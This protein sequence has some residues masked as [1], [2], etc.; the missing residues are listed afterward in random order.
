MVTS[1]Y[2]AKLLGTV[3]LNDDHIDM[4]MEE[5]SKEVSSDPGLVDKVIIARLLFAQQVLNVKERYTWKN[6]PLLCHY[7]K[8]IK[9][10][11]AKELYFPIHVNVNH[12][13]VGL[14]DFKNK[15]ISFGQF[16]LICGICKYSV[17]SR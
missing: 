4:M 1:A 14:I 5:L 2:L 10:N 8:H 9:E 13:I 11:N 12:W 17:N 16:Y 3:W 7:E 6:A 15:T